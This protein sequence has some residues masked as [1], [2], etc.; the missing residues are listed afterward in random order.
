MVAQLH[1]LISLEF[2]M[3]GGFYLILNDDMGVW[4]LCRKQDSPCI[5][6]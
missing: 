1:S 2:A 3:K 4:Q 5:S 6:S